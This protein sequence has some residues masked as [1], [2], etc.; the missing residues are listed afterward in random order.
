M[1]IINHTVNRFYIQYIKIISF[2]NIK[3]NSKFI[4]APPIEL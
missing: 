2:Y 3:S 4:V 1:K